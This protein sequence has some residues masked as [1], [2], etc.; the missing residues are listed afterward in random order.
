MDVLD[1]R[2]V[3]HLRALFNLC[4]K[5]FSPSMINDIV[6]FRRFKLLL[7]REYSPFF[8]FFNILRIKF[9]KQCC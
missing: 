4:K 5:I 1:H 3:I 7:S 6:T 2:L 8:L 9:C